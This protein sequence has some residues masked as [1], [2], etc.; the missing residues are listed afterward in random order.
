[1]TVTVTVTVTVRYQGGNKSKYRQSEL[2]S[3]VMIGAF[4]CHTMCIL[5]TSSEGKDML[6]TQ[7]AT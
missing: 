1:M 2:K 7:H 4:K 6:Q 5:A 3:S